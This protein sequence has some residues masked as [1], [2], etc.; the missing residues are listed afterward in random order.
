MLSE[1]NIGNLPRRE[2]Q[3]VRRRLG[4]FPVDYRK[5]ADEVYHGAA[6]F[7][8]CL[9]L[10]ALP[11]GLVRKTR[12][13][14]EALGLLQKYYLFSSGHDIILYRYASVFGSCGFTLETGLVSDLQPF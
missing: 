8:L 12:L 2:H 6:E 7:R 13:G 1:C 10:V 5:Q 4:L 11:Y 14:K 3:R 9:R